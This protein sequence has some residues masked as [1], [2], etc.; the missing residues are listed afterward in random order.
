MAG[1]YTRQF[2]WSTVLVAACAG[3]L[4]AQTNNQWKTYNAT[5]DGDSNQCSGGS[6]PVHAMLAIDPEQEIRIAQ[7]QEEDYTTLQLKYN[8]KAIGVGT[9]VYAIS[10]HFKVRVRYRD[11]KEGSTTKT[12]DGDDVTG[13]DVAM[14]VKGKD[15]TQT[16]QELFVHLPYFKLRVENHGAQETLTSPQVH[17]VEIACKD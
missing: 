4:T 9:T 14:I 16:E 11:P 1:R 17:I 3:T 15:T 5:P 13:N 12:F 7:S 6:A 10:G 8:A 2:L